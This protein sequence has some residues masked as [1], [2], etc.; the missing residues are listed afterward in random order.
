[1]RES[2]VGGLE[3]MIP[4][5]NIKVGGHELPSLE[6]LKEGTKGLI[7]HLID[8][9]KS[10]TIDKIKNWLEAKARES[11]LEV[12]KR[13]VTYLVVI[14]ACNNFGCTMKKVEFKGI[15]YS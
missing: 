13:E 10:S 3:I 2:L 11:E 1:M 8:K 14:Q 5:I 6:N 4:N 7:N 15:G 12:R 9:I